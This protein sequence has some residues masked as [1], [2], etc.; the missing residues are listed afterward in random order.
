MKQKGIRLSVALP[1]FMLICGIITIAIYATMN[2]R[3][4][5]AD[6]KEPIAFD[7]NSTA[8]N[9]YSSIEIDFITPAVSVSH[10]SGYTTY[11]LYG[12][13]KTGE[14]GIALV[15]YFNEE[16]LFAESETVVL[17]GTAQEISY[18]VLSELTVKPDKSENEFD[19]MD[20][21]AIVTYTSHAETAFEEIS[22][23]GIDVG[24]DSD[25]GDKVF[26]ASFE[27]EKESSFIFEG[28]NIIGYIACAGF[29][30]SILVFLGI[31]ILGI[32]VFEKK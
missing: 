31:V 2:I 30:L 16:T 20:V 15:D 28:V 29:V 21:G 18:G 8:E 4:D 14:F 6:V 3:K 10:S 13:S 22:K 7:K 9:V 27:P 12:N 25:F 11:Y 19:V 5:L 23:K 1:V 24:Y 32:P 17:Y 26:L